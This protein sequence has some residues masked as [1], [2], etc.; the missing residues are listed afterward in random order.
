MTTTQLLGI[1]LKVRQNPEERSALIEGIFN[2]VGLY[3]DFSDYKT[4]LKL[5]DE[6]EPKS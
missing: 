3:P 4:F 2:A 6:S 5:R 1:L